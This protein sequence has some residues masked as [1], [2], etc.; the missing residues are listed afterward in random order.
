MKRFD[1]ALARVCARRKQAGISG[2]RGF[3]QA[4][5]QNLSPGKMPRRIATCPK[6]IRTKA[7]GNAPRYG[8]GRVWLKAFHT[9]R[10]G[11]LAPVCE[12]LYDIRRDCGRRLG[13]IQ[14]S[15]A[16]ALGLLRNSGKPTTPR[17][18]RALPYA[19]LQ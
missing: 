1:H 9:R 11:M 19:I 17:I 15:L 14:A 3:G 16:S 6:G 18:R 8:Q 12:S 10:V 7:W 4:Q 5:A 2:I 13:I